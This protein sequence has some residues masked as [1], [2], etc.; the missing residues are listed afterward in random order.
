MGET[1]TCSKRDRGQ[2]KIDFAGDMLIYQGGV[3]S[4][5]ELIQIEAAADWLR[6]LLNESTRRD[7]LADE[8]LSLVAF[9]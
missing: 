4:N 1:K 3:K 7:V 2:S 9:P 5:E 6:Q 8:D